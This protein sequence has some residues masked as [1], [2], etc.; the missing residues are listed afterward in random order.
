L[1]LQALAPFAAL[2]PGWALRL[3]P[4]ALTPT[5]PPMTD[6]ACVS[7]LTVG[8]AAAAATRKQRSATT[9][10][11]KGRTSTTTGVIDSS[12]SNGTSKQQQQRLQQQRALELLAIT[13]DPFGSYLVDPD[14]L[15]T[16]KQVGY[17]A[18]NVKCVSWPLQ[19]PHNLPLN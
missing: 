5:I 13:E 19:S 9:G 4:A 8:S 16:V 17:D 15:D 12:S 6:N 2:I 18:V 14:T 3:L 11:E 10:K 7:V 1:L